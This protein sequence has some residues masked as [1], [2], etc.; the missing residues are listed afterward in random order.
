MII[1]NRLFSRRERRGPYSPRGPVIVPGGWGG[2]M[3]TMAWRVGGGFSG[4]ERLRRRRRSSAG[5]MPFL[6]DEDRQHDS[7]RDR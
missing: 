6:T 5:D 2:G 3:A 7:E 1:L 4:G